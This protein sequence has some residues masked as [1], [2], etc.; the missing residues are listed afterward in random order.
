MHG[1][2]RTVNHRDSAQPIDSRS[3]RFEADATCH[4]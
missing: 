1:S 2:G 4:D 3:A